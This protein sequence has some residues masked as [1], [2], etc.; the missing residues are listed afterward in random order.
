[1]VDHGNRVVVSFTLVVDLPIFGGLVEGDIVISLALPVGGG[2]IDLLS[3]VDDVC[4]GGGVSAALDGLEVG[5]VEG[6]LDR[7]SLFGVHLQ[8]FLY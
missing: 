1:M 2:S 8:H 7:D 6:L 4:G 3:R 5:V